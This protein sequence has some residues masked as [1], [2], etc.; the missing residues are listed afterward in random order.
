MPPSHRSNLKH[1]K[2]ILV[3]LFGSLGDSIVAIPA[4]R[5]VRRHFPDAEIVLLQNFLTADL[6]KASQVIPDDLVDRNLSYNSGL[7]GVGKVSN[8][9]HLWRLLRRERFEAAVY[10]VIS[11]RPKKAVLRDRVF[12]KS[13]GI[14]KLIGFT[15][16]SNK[17][18]Y[19]VDTSGHPAMTEHEAVRKLRR[20]AID[21][22]KFV[23][24]DLRIPLLSFSPIEGENIDKWLESRRRNLSGPLI[25]IA[26]GCKTQANAWPL[27]NFIQL[28]SR[29]IA[30]KNCEIIVVGGN[31]EREIGEQLIAAWGSG[32]NSAGAFSVRES[33][34][35]LAK[36]DLY[37]GLDTG[38]THLAAVVGTKCFAIYGERNNP[39]HW[40]PLGNGHAVVFHPVK[41]A[42]C[43]L[44][45]C[46]LP[47]HPCMTGISL[48]SVWHNLN[49]FLGPGSGEL[50]TQII[51][52]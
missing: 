23:P 19:P 22:I 18:L 46:P 20:L 12:F 31:A 39:G 28:G 43:R 36:C 21:G 15:P 48:E 47:D 44:Q 32:I 13:C 51:S 2:K 9:F 50:P 37:I 5:A 27:E 10:L 14:P 24:E 6:V 33:G 45:D 8:F 26:P 25:A 52:V 1:K 3:Y 42:G 35:L 16:F 17:E 30:E 34:A 40:F 29:L 41:C 38:T 7:G 11:E 49:E 4:L